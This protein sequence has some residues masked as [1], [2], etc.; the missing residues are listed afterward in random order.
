MVK[1][2]WIL[3][4][5]EKEERRKSFFVAVEYRA[6]EMQLALIKQQINSALCCI[7]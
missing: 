5:M 6:D 4:G 3:S 1:W 2:K 7:T